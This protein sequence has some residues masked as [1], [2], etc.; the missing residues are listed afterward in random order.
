MKKTRQL[1]NTRKNITRRVVFAYAGIPFPFSINLISAVQRQ[2]DF[3]G[4]MVNN[5]WIN[6]ME[7]Q[8]NAAIRYHKFLLLMKDHPNTLFVPTL[9]IDLG[10][11][12]HQIHASLYREFTQK[13]LG[14]I[15]NHDDT[16]ADGTLSN[17]FATTA[18]AWYKK[19][20]EP[21][22]HV[23]PSKYWLSTKKK[24]MSIVVPPYGLSVLYKLKKYKKA[25][26][27]DVSNE[28][29]EKFGK[30]K[31]GKEKDMAK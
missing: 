7:V 12:T 19:Y 24:I 5:D 23:N 16:L 1:K 26:T 17:G 29:N 10:W 15:I 25:T 4:K 28:T 20:H 6:C 2:R 3:T 27:K 22:T 31:N 18:R 21:Y 8:S 14:R 30:R 9:D 11:H 13:H